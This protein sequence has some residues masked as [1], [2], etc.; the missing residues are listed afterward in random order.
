MTQTLTHGQRAL[1]EAALTQRQHQLDRRLAEHHSGLSRAEHAREPGP[2]ALDVP[3]QPRHRVAG[4]QHDADRQR[5]R[6]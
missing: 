4:G 2:H 1:L 6:G 5:I 3:D